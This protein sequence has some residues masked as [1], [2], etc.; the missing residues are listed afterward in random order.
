V[1]AADAPATPPGG[2][3]GSERIDLHGLRVA[4]ALD[5]LP[6]ALDR[7]LRRGCDRLEIVHGRGTGALREAV[8]SYLV[9]SPFANAFAPGTPEE[10]GEGVTVVFLD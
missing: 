1:H 9:D 8:R 6:V 2:G 7:A 3:G 4:E 5:R 10:G